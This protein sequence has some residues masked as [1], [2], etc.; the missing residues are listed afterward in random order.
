MSPPGSPPFYLP[1]G[2]EVRVFTAAWRSGLPV[3]VKGPTGYGKT[4][5]VEHVAHLVGVP[6]RTV[7]C[8][9]EMTAS[10]LVGRFTLA[11]RE[12]TWVDGPLTRAVREGAICYLDEIV[13]AHQDAVVAI[14]P[15]ADHRRELTIERLGG[16]TVPAA[17]GFQLVLSY[18]PCYQSV[19]KDLKIST[20]QRMVSIE[21]DFPPAEL[22]RSV[23]MAEAPGLPEAVA[24]ELVRLGQSIR[25]LRDSGLR[26]A[27]STR[28]LIAAGALLAAGLSF[29]EAVAAAVVGPLTDDPAT[30][31]GL[32]V[33]VDAFAGSA[34]S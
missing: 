27:A 26:E 1:Q 20:R 34:A 32:L 15:L 6:L 11:G 17:D 4:R 13:E 23:L 8:H 25:R 33:L 2:N 22:E 29:R 9:E 5:L 14:H 19:P 30:R 28:M 31:D 10:D 21:L 24:E 18:N 12:M 3:M 16:V 7:S